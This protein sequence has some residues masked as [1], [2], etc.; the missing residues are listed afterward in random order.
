MRTIQKLSSPGTSTALD[1]I[2]NI[3]KNGKFRFAYRY[4]GWS[5]GEVENE[6]KILR[7][8]FPDYN[9]WRIEW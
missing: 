7:N 4:Q 5:S 3:Y 6:V 2:V 8:R 1:Y 9:G